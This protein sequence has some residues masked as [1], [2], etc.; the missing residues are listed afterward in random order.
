MTNSSIQSETLVS[1]DSEKIDDVY[2]EEFAK[3]EN[4]KELMLLVEDNQELRE[5][6]RSIF[7]PMYRVVEAA[8]GKEG[9]KQGF[10]VPAGYYHQ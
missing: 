4:S 2:G 8:D 5:F 9:G 10:E 1:D 7:S 6:L 3:E